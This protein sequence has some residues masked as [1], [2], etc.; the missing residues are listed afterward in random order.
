M[1]AEYAITEEKNYQDLIKLL[2]KHLQQLI[3][4]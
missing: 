2:W 4:C 3:N 1:P